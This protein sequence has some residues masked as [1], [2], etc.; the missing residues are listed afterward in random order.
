[1]YVFL[2]SYILL[3]LVPFITLFFLLSNLLALSSRPF[4]YCTPT[5]TSTSML[6]A[7]HSTLSISISLC[8]SLSLTFYSLSLS[9][10]LSHT[11]FVS[12]S[13]SFSLFILLSLSFSLSFSLSLSVVINHYGSEHKLLFSKDG[14][15]HILSFL[16]FMPLLRM[17]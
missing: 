13:L 1:M 3:T 15:T 8:L 7:S 11:L 12:F 2:S 10:S 17:K 14:S 5:Y 4:F 16:F 6:F 9:I